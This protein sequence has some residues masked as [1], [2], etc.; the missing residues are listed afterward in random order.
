MK[1]I[2]L[3]AVMSEY[4]NVQL[5]DTTGDVLDIYDGRDAISPE[6]NEYEVTHIDADLLLLDWTEVPRIIIE[7]EEG[8]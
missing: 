6:Y 1:L 4:T 3:L 7:V 2:E 8:E 5:V